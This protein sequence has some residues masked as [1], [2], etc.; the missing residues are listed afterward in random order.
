MAGIDFTTRS[1]PVSLIKNSGGLNSTASPIGVADNEA[2]ELQNIDF[3]RFGA[4]KKRNGFTLLNT[5]AVNSG[6]ACTSLHFFENRTADYLLGTFGNKLYKM[7]ALDGT[8]DDIT[9]GLTITPGSTNLFSWITFNNAAYGTNGVNLPIKVDTTP[10]ASTFTVPTGL[11]TAKYIESFE[12]YA[13]LANCTV[14]GTKR[15]TRLYWSTI[16]DAETWDAADFNEIG[17]DDGEEITGLKKLGDRIAI[18]KERS[19]YVGLFTGDADIPFVFKKTPSEIGCVSG[20]SIQEALNGH[21]FLS[22]DG[23]YFFDGFNVTKLSDRISTTIEELNS[24]RKLYAVS[25]YQ[26][27]KNKYWLSVSSTSGGH[28]RIITYDCFNNAFSIYKG[29]NANAIVNMN[30]AGNERLYFGNYTGFACRADVPNQTSDKSDANVDVAIEGVYKTKWFDFGDVV[31][32]K[33]VAQSVFY[34][35]FANTMLTFSY[36]YDLEDGNDISQTFNLSQG[37][38]E[39]DAAIWDVDEWVKAGGGFKRVDH[40]G[41]GR[42]MRCIFYNNNIGEEFKINAFGLFVHM[43]THAG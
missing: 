37:G 21:L 27:T 29:I 11:T 25:G 15:A 10:T 12:N 28:D 5:T 1:T 3:D 39:W 40:K 43:E 41:R 38:A 9:G 13:F 33:G 4:F 34:Y 19:I 7:D 14:S 23:I 18:Y 20:W 32:Q 17:L 16:D 6:A 30:Y 35:D 26:K 2:S 42:L 31:L 24:N 22:V 36:S 8:W